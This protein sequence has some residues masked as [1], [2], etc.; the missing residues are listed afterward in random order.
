MKTRQIITHF[1]HLLFPLELL[2]TF[3]FVFENSQ[4]S[5]LCGTRFGPFWSVKYL[6]FGRKLPI[7]TIHHTFLE[8]RHPEVTKNP[9]YVLSPKGSQKKVSAH[10]LYHINIVPEFGYSIAMFKYQGTCAGLV[11]YSN[12]MVFFIAFYLLP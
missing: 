7:Q 9:Y 12:R 3:I 1:F 10:R 5:F 11:T 8:C 4:N 6:N 2:V